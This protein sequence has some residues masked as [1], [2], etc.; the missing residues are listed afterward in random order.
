MTIREEILNV[1]SSIPWSDI[2]KGVFSV[3]VSMAPLFVANTFL[4]FVNPKIIEDVWFVVA[5]AMI[6]AS[7]IAYFTSLPI[8]GRP[9]LMPGIVAGIVFLISLGLLLALTG[10]ILSAKPSYAALLARFL[11]IGL[12][13]GIA[14]VIAWILAW[15]LNRSA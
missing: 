12:F 1:L 9:K 10:D 2:V 8:S 6:P 13:T 5:L 14:G 3:G 15:A 7:G 11:L 4:P